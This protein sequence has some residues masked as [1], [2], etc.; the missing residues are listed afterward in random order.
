[1]QQPRWS[2]EDVKRAIRLAQEAGLKSYR[3]EIS[4][5]GTLTIIVDDGGG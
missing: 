4:A 5:D 1:L 2:D 3:V